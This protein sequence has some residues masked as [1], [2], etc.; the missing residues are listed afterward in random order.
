MGLSCRGLT[1][2]P[3]Q[4]PGH[5]LSQSVEA[6]YCLAQNPRRAHALTQG[7]WQNP[8]A[9]DQTS[10]KCPLLSVAAPATETGLRLAPQGHQV[11][12]LLKAPFPQLSA[13]LT[14][15]LCLLCPHQKGFP[16]RRQHH[17]PAPAP[18]VGSANYQPRADTVSAE[19]DWLEHSLPSS[20]AHCLW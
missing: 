16:F 8:M 3:T 9:P 19:H 15:G 12:S 1:L 14:S 4:Q 17:S 13:C 10:L 7:T 2:S 20:C 5:S 6:W 18:M 11:C